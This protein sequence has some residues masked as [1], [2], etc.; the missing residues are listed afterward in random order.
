MFFQEFPKINYK[1]RIGDIELNQVEI[2]DVFR[3]VTY[4][5]KL[6]SIHKRPVTNYIPVAG[7]TPEIIADKFYGDPSYWWLVCIFSNTLNPFTGF[8]RTEK[9]RSEQPTDYYDGY[10]YLEQEG[11]VEQRGIKKGDYIVLGSGDTQRDYAIPAYTSIRSAVFRLPNSNKIPAPKRD[12]NGNAT[13][14]QVVSYDP[15]TLK[16]GVVGD[17][18]N[19][20]VG[21][22]KFIVMSNPG[23]ED[24]SLGQVST[25]EKPILELG[26]KAFVSATGN[27]LRKEQRGENTL[28]GFNDRVTGFPVS[29][30]TDIRTRKLS[31][32]Y[33]NKAS[34]RVGHTFGNTIIGGFLGTTGNAGS[35]Y[36]ERYEPVYEILQMSTLPSSSTTRDE[37]ARVLKLL[38]P[39]YKEEAFALFR[40]SIQ[41]QRN[42]RRTFSSFNSKGR[43]N[44]S[45][46]NGGY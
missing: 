34:D 41:D 40:Q 9:D 1:F 29:G 13:V 16:T 23:D 17:I 36:N 22:D 37:S 20:E 15:T 32:L 46:S 3:R 25:S 45:S 35:T 4:N 11:G 24:Y 39:E 21:S 19:V 38:N 18:G 27:I 5:L 31:S 26:G 14:L 43:S 33:S 30:L 6:S 2:I 10:M 42:V 12:G 8:P 7:D 44:P 28:I